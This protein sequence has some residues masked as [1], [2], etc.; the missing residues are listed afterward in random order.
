MPERRG[1]SKAP[2]WM[3]KIGMGFGRQW[4]GAGEEVE[5]K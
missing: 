5:G 2:F 3:E 1:A 4:R